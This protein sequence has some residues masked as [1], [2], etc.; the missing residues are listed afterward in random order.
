VQTSL[1]LAI[2]AA[3]AATSLALALLIGSKVFAV[4][5]RS[6]G[7]GEWIR[8]CLG[9]AVLAAVLVI[10][11]GFDTSFLTQVSLASTVSLE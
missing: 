3:G 8:R 1:L 2:Y 7:I 9:A 11:M 6:L 10:A 4:M 5:K